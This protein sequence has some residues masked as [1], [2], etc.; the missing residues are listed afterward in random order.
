MLRSRYGDAPGQGEVPDDAGTFIP[1]ALLT[2]D[3]SVNADRETH[4]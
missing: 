2:A 4:R 3:P 1:L